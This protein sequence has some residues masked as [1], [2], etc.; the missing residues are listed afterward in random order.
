MVFVVDASVATALYVRDPLSRQ[1][2]SVVSQVERSGDQLSAPDLLVYEVANA[3][4]KRARRDAIRPEEAVAAIDELLRLDVQLH[5]GSLL[6]RAALALAMAHD[7]TAYDA[8]YLALCASLGGTLLT[9]DTGLSATA[10]SAGFAVR[11][12]EPD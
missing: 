9:G 5:P 6:A 10:G 3:I 12:I 11:V 8:S 1:A 7:L 2:K 4:W